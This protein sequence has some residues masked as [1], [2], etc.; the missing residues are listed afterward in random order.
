MNTSLRDL[1]RG[2]LWK[3]KIYKSVYVFLN[4]TQDLSSFKAMTF[5]RLADHLDRHVSVFPARRRRKVFDRP[6]LGL[7]R[8]HPRVLGLKSSRRHL[9][10]QLG[11]RPHGQNT[12]QC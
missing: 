4:Q 2:C 10:D 5:K 8:R 9:R 3:K 1:D 11:R 7:P 6:Q 12:F